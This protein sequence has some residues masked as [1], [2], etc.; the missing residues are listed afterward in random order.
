MRRW[1]VLLALIDM[2]SVA[3]AADSRPVI[4]DKIL[5]LRFKDI[6]CLN[7]SLADLGKKRAYVFVFTTTQCPIV[8]RSMP[9]L[10]DF[11]RRFG[12]RDVQFVAVNVGLEET[13]RDMAAQAIEF[14]A[15]F[16]FVKDFDYSCVKSLGVSRTPE[17]VVLNSEQR[18]VYRG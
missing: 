3:S 1:I 10:V 13:I 11:D 17:V 5:D 4:G 16:P 14:D 7:R 12:S 2:I 6:R 18:L 8:K 9:T 15:A